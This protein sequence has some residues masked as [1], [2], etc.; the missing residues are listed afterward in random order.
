M[1]ITKTMY[2]AGDTLDALGDKML[3]R[4]VLL[5][6]LDEIATRSRT[7]LDILSNMERQVLSLSFLSICVSNT[8][9][10]Y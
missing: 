10:S 9:L 1:K 4:Q 6:T 3:S 5:E 2:K 8:I 7:L